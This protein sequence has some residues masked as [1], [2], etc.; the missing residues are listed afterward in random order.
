MFPI[1][2][3]NTV[4]LVYSLVLA[5]GEDS[6]LEVL[7]LFNLFSCQLG[8]GSNAETASLGAIWLKEALQVGDIYLQHRSP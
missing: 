7:V 6:C 3:I 8:Q 1:S 5:R 4:T 2:K